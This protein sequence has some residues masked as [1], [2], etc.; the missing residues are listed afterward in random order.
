MPPTMV[1]LFAVACGVSAANL[2]YAQPLL[3]LIS[4]DLQVG[5][6]PPPWW[7]PPPRSATDWDWP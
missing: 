7:S 1:A 2:Y 5:S 4:R 6:G 3:P